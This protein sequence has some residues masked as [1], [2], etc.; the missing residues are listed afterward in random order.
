METIAASYA[1][2]KL[3]CFFILWKKITNMK[4]STSANRVNVKGKKRAEN[5]DNLDHRC[6]EEQD[7]KGNDITHNEKETKDKHLKQKKS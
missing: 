5:K 6:N 4:T 7:F 2:S 3:A 1:Y